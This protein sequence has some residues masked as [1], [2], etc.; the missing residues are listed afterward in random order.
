M[1]DDLLLLPTPRSIVRGSGTV[2][3]PRSVTVSGAPAALLAVFPGMAA[4]A[5]GW[6]ACRIDAGVG[7]RAEAYRLTVAPGATPAVRI[8][9]RDE[10]GLRWGLA[11]LAQLLRI[12]PDALPALAIEDAPAFAHRGTMLDISRDRVPTMAELKKLIDQLA[13]WKQNHFQLYVEHTVAYAGH[14][15]AWRAASPLS[16]D[17]IGELDRYAAARG[18]ALTANQNCFG[19]V[20]RWLR[21]PRYAPLGEVSAPRMH[22]GTWYLEPST[23]NPTDPRSVELVR[24]W[25][26]QLLPRCSGAYA[27]IGCDEPWDLGLGRSKEACAA[28]GAKAVFSAFVSQVAAEVVK[29]G[30]KPQFWCD[31]HP[32][33]DD[34]LPR[35]LLALVWGYDAKTDFTGRIRSHRALGREAWVC[36]GTN[37]WGSWTSRTANR[38]GNLAAATA[39]GLAEGATGLLMTEWGDNGHRQQ[40]PLTIFGLADGAQAAW[41]GAADCDDRASGLHALG[42]SALGAWLAEL[43]DI[44][45]QC[46]VSVF[47]DVGL[48]LWD[49]SG[50]IAPWKD[51]AARFAALE[52][53]LPAVGGLIERE[54]RHA[55]AC[56]RWGAERAVARR[57]GVTL[58]A[59]KTIAAGMCAIIAEHRALWLQRSRPGGLEDS[60]QHYRRHTVWW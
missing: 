31:P 18:I 10:A 44:D 34:A 2:P 13:S 17:E 41:S 19:H 22:N 45:R 59:R 47:G 20:E 30:K 42:S 56:A 28:R 51:L 14:E 26:G 11:T 29:L 6:C 21:H 40:W 38:R 27:N 52:A 9:G 16:L 3:V 15:D 12:H 32:N 23:L 55:I 36:P 25:L 53:R 50:D 35:D 5:S 4:A 1:T 46:G 48:N 43:G 39:Q 60:C 37:C 24:D 58:E 33:E 7:D 54:C 57:T 8:E 49:V